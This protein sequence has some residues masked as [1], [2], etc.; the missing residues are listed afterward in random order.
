MS[1]RKTRVLLSF[2]ESKRMINGPNYPVS[3]GWRDGEKAL[4]LPNHI[5][6]YFE[7]GMT[8]DRIMYTK[9]GA[10]PVHLYHAETKDGGRWIVSEQFP[11]KLDGSTD[12]LY[13]SDLTE[14]L[15]PP[16]IGRIDGYAVKFEMLIDIGL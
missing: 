8:N 1:E 11:Y 7:S 9:Y 2:L 6:L 10:I 3:L 12:I 15:Q 5:G 16:R 4:Q 14:F 13:Q